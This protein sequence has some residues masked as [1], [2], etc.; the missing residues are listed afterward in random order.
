MK[1][2]KYMKLE[3]MHPKGDWYKIN[4]N[5]PPSPTMKRTGNVLADNTSKETR[6]QGGVYPLLNRSAG[7]TKLYMII[8]KPVFGLESCRIS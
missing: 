6:L 3:I 1:K 2:H 7:V 4:G 5:T 8:L